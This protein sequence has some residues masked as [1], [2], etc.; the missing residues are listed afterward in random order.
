MEALRRIPKHNR[1][2]NANMRESLIV[3][4]LLALAFAADKEIHIGL[5]QGHSVFKEIRSNI[6]RWLMED[7]R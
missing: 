3:S 4:L 5:G 1:K 6:D 7:G 2:E